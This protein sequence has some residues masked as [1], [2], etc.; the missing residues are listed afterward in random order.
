MQLHANYMCAKHKYCTHWK[1]VYP[2]PDRYLVY[3]ARISALISASHRLWELLASTTFTPS[4]APCQTKLLHC[5]TAT[6]NYKEDATISWHDLLELLLHPLHL[7]SHMFGK[8][9]SPSVTLWSNSLTKMFLL[10]KARAGVGN[11]RIQ[12][13]CVNHVVAQPRKDAMTHGGPT[14]TSR[15]SLL[16]HS[17]YPA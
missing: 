15:S 16:T 8:H 6:P 4:E 13:A 3:F 9:Y 11:Q 17:Q 7:G 12:A 5:I 2:E 1:G 10:S 14:L